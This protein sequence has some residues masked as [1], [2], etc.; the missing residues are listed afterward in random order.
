LLKVVLTR[1]IVLLIAI[2][3]AGLAFGAALTTT[4]GRVTECVDGGEESKPL[5]LN[6]K[7]RGQNR[8]RLVTFV[9]TGVIIL[10]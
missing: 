9:G 1:D 5:V 3:L 4:D 2:L 8:Y 10:W 7:K 6:V